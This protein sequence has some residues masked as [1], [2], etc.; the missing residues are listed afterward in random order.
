MA[1]IPDRRP[2]WGRRS[3]MPAAA[4]FLIA[5]LG[6]GSWQYTQARQNRLE[7][8]QAKAKL[9]YAL[10]VTTSKLQTP[11]ARLLR[12]TGGLI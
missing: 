7:A 6:A 5:V 9:I 10:Q 1:R 4:A 3:W 2:M 12:T 11:Q 8:E